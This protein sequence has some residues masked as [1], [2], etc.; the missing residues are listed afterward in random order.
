MIKEIYAEDTWEIRHK[1]MWPEKDLNYVKLKDD[2]K[3]KHYGVFEENKMVSVISLFFSEDGAQFRKFATL[4]KEQGKGYGRQLLKFV[5]EKT[6]KDRIN[7]IWCNARYD[8]I[9]F[10]KKFGMVETNESFRKGGI[11]YIIMRKYLK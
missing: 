3:G 5:M 2:H 9:D 11:D 8:K 6:K 4:K 10:Y 1:V 7:H